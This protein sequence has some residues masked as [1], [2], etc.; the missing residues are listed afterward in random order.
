[1]PELRR[2]RCRHSNILPGDQCRLRQG[3]RET[4]GRSA[5]VRSAL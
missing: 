2:V 4:G 5:S 3:V 1:L